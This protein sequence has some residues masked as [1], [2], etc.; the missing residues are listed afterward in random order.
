[1]KH[2]IRFPFTPVLFAAAALASATLA[3]AQPPPPL[4]PFGI[5]T[6]YTRGH[7]L[8]ANNLW[9]P[10]L[11]EID[12]RW[13]RS[14]PGPQMWDVEKTKGTYDFK[15]I[16]ASI[17]YMDKNGMN[18]C[19][20][21]WGHGF[22]GDSGFPKND[23]ESWAEYVR[24]TV[25]RFAS[26][27][28]TGLYYE[29][30]NEPPNFTAKGDTAADFARVV[31]AA[32]DAAKSADPT[33]QIGLSAK[34][35]HINWL[36]HVIRHGAKN[37][38]DWISL[39]PYESLHGVYCMTGS[40]A[41]YLSVVPTLRKMLRTLNPERADVPVMFTEI[42]V[43]TTGQQDI[44]ADA[45]VKCYVM[46]IAQGVAQI[47][48]FEAMDGDA[49]P[50]GILDNDAKPRLAYHA[51]GTMIKHL[52][53]YP[54]YLGWT[55]LADKH[56]GYA[57]KGADG[58]IL[59]AAWT[60]KKGA[61]DELPLGP[62]PYDVVHSHTGDTVKTNALKLTNTPVYLLAPPPALIEQAR[63]NKNKPFPWQ[64]DYTD[65]KEI[66]ISYAGDGQVI[67]KGLH[68]VSGEQVVAAI[69]LYGDQF[70]QEGYRDGST[71]GGES[72]ICD[73]NFLSYKTGP[74]EITVTARHAVYVGRQFC[75]AGE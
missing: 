75:G 51:Y 21:L 65:A 63:A 16:D 39:H 62:A 74:I 8:W 57:F 15:M 6:G 56:L 27:G 68:N 33:A 29:I 44:H 59:L 36:A 70:A 17:E 26:K 60:Q 55:L 31:A 69:K 9:L 3:A 24:Q 28:K 23:I 66:S 18:Y 47:H 54:E 37:K 43:F 12:V 38:F 2:I 46:G 61:T 30:W 50:M 11:R 71:W 25:A 34:S 10:Q 41:L 19:V 52:G 40:D 73:P 5:G 58:K 42:G 7:A 4:S 72:F 13:Y 20:L 49:G 22:K 14:P 35:A 67:E 64:G 45:L 1:M 53:Q 48:W 32:Y